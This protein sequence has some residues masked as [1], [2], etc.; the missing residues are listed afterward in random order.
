M[1]RIVRVEIPKNADDLLKLAALVIA[2]H[3]ELGN[4]SPIKGVN[5]T[6]MFTKNSEANYNNAK[7]AEQRRLAEQSKELRDRGLGFAAGQNTGTEGTLYFYLTAIR[8]ILL[9]VYKGKEHRL[10]EFGFEVSSNARASSEP[11]E[12]DKG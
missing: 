12:P 2:K 9:G 1:R 6:D 11:E 5:M 8:D 3:N 7:A 10:G 4:L